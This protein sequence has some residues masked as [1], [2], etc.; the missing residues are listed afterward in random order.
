MKR[1]IL[2]VLLSIFFVFLMS[3]C[4]FLGLEE[5]NN[6]QSIANEVV[7]DGT[8]NYCLQKDDTYFISCVNPSEILSLEIPKIYNEKTIS[9]IDKNGF[10]DCINLT[11]VII[12]E[13]IISIGDYAFANCS[14]LNDIVIPDN[15]NSIGKSSF[16]G[17]SML[18]QISLPFVGK[19]RYN[20]SD[21]YHYPFGY[22]F[23]SE[24]YSGSNKTEQCYYN[25][26]KASKINY[27]IPETLTNVTIT[28]DMFLQNSAFYNCKNIEEV[29]LSDKI[30]AI[31]KS[32]FF[33][34]YGL[35]DIVLP[36]NVTKIEPFTFM[37]CVSL[38]SVH[39]GNNVNEIGNA[40]F[41]MCS[42]LNNINIPSSVKTIGEDAFYA[43]Y[44]LQDI[45]LGNELISIGEKAFYECILLQ[46]IVIPESVTQIGSYAFQGC[47]NLKSVYL[48]KGLTKLQIY[49]FSDCEKLES[50]VISGDVDYISYCAFYKCKSLTRVY[51][52]GSNKLWDKK[53]DD[54]SYFYN[55]K[56]Y[57]YSEDEPQAS[58]NYWHY[59]DGIITVWNNQNT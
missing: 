45:T 17:C 39:L 49:V 8:Y 11:S 51:V 25:N 6:D 1:N 30:K 47:K 2:I 53:T 27:Y 15:V 4:D 37:C 12:P 31:G 46:N 29:N 56:T 24:Y 10:K 16:S 40:A 52:L 48:P 44:G 42:S 22:I 14:Q 32:S 35:K 19:N 43:C 58:G 57:Y 34:C 3:S 13:S 28:D 41:M 20:S 50:V 18:K 5:T 38:A 21:E 54:N 36:E 26:D 55:A 33:S 7:S 23:G 59:V 9:G